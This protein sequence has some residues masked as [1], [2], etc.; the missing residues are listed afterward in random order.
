MWGLCGVCMWGVC[1]AERGVCVCVCEGG[2]VCT[3]METC[4]AAL[5]TILPLPIHYMNGTK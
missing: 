2:T 1:G 4:V 5:Y 3:D